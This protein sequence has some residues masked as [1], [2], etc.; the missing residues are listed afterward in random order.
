MAR[1]RLNLLGGFTVESIDGTALGHLPRK[2]RALLAYLALSDP[3]A[4]SRHRLAGLLWPEYGDVQARTSLR[5][6]LTAIRKQIGDILK[7]DKEVVALVAGALYIDVAEFEVLASS[8]TLDMQERAIQLYRGDFLDGFQSDTSTFD[9]WRAIERE[10][11]HLLAIDVA[12]RALEWHELNGRIDS[13]VL[14]ANRIA[15]LDPL[16]EDAHRALM[17]MYA[18]QARPALALKQY[19]VC[20]MTLQRELGVSPEPATEQLFREVS[21]GRRTKTD[22]QVGADASSEDTNWSTPDDGAKSWLESAVVESDVGGAAVVETTKALA[23]GKRE[24]ATGFASERRQLTVMFSDMVG[25]T[26]LENHLDP[27]VLQQI[28]RRYEDACSV[29]IMRYDGFVHQ[30]RGG[31]IVAFFGYPR[32]HEDEAERAIRA[33]LDIIEAL[34]ALEV[35]GVGRLAARIG[36]ATGPMVVSLADR[37]AVGDAI[38]TASR[39][40]DIALP[41]SIVVS[42]PVQRLARGALDYEDLGEQTLKGAPRPTRAFRVVG[43]SHAANRFEAATQEKLT[44]LVGREQEIGLFLERWSL[45][46]DGEG[47]VVLLSGEPGIG[48][49]RIL[50]TLRERLQ[51]QGVRAL[52]FQCS[53][54]YVNSALWPSIDNIERALKFERGELPEPKLDKLEALMVTQYG[55]PLS[56]MRFVASMLSIPCEQRY[57]A[58]SMSPQK[59][60]DE[61]LRTIVDLTEAAARKQPSVML[62]EDV[63]WA[64]PTTLEVLDLLIDRVRTIPLLV[65]LTHRPEFQ[66]RWAQHGHVIGLNL[67]KL[68]RAQSGAMVARLAG[69]KTLPSSL[70]KQILTKTDGVPL[71]VEELTNSILESGELKEAGDHYEYA[72]DMRSISI[73]ATLRDSLMARLDRFVPVKE[74]AQIGAAIGREFSYELIAAVAPM[75]QSQLDT[76]LSQLTYSGLAFRRG[77]PPDAT[78]TFKHALVQDA[79]YDSLLKSPRQELHAK[80]ARVIEERFPGVKDTEPELLAH[81]LSAAGADAAA[82][83]SWYKAAT[84]AVERVALLDAMAHCARGLALL[85]ALPDSQDRARQE[86]ALQLVLGQAAAQAKGWAAPEPEQ[87]F[88][89]ARALCEAIG[90]APEVFPALWGVWAFSVVAGRMVAAEAVALEFLGHAKRSGDSAAVCEG[91]RI[92]GE[93]ALHL[94]DLRRARAHLEEGIGVYDAEAHRGNIKLYG[95][96]SG[97]TNLVYLSSVLWL[98]GY[99]DQSRRAQ[100][101]AMELAER[102]GQPFGL[103]WAHIFDTLLQ[104]NIRNWTS[105]GKAAAEV[106]A[107]STEHGYAYWLAWGCINLGVARMHGHAESQAGESVRKQID[108]L[109]SVG[110]GSG[111]TWAYALLADAYWAL[112]GIDEGLDQVAAGLALVEKTEERYAE[113]ELLRVQGELLLSCGR[114]F[115]SQAEACFDRSIEI[116]RHQQ[117]KSWELRTSTSL[118]RLWQSQGKRKEALG[119]LKPVYNWFTEGFDAHDLKVA[120]ELLESLC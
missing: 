11:L 59:F 39:L 52:R 98:L 104:G 83:P 24:A 60:K 105:M 97:M 19:Q 34:S 119:L 108:V 23:G 63:H 50:N 118:A 96:D 51:D 95:Q 43:V 84:N 53:P 21:H 86:L 22:V 8:G 55:R 93:M 25:F 10:R 28:V 62:F 35:P 7:T 33:G 73:P 27:E 112:G 116:A 80:I 109:R 54:Y 38:N 74:I 88:S 48:K 120:R 37:G 66:S 91:Q 47:Q 65:V 117:A 110:V 32:A 100:Q 40:Q 5:Q 102:S 85:S 99:P 77:T 64:D 113:S 92:V 29:C 36:I 42:E 16:R 90:D 20:R 82:I 94:G 75:R 56:D 18:R 57:G 4:Q 114:K 71:F 41:C 76:A 72:G 115:H 45:A 87:A 61:T 103:A 46:Q 17:R 49:S 44:P 2:A 78:Y 31:G 89:R 13:A 6:A 70:V 79:A 15:T 81:H 14:L 26:E 30:R 12:T 69:I 101:G 1:I 68:T 9:Q 107:V 106:V 111:L 67:S 3:P 58:P